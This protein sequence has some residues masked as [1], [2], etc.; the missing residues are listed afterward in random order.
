MCDSVRKKLGHTRHAT[1]SSPKPL[2]K[3]R[4][5]NAICWN[6]FFKQML[7]VSAFYLEKEK[8]FTLRLIEIYQNT[9]T[10][11]IFFKSQSLNMP[12]QIQKMALAVLIFSEGFAKHIIIIMRK[13]NLPS[14][15][16]FLF[17]GQTGNVSPV[18]SNFVGMGPVV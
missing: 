7:K 13:I 2:L 15:S 10:K 17:G 4:T 11:R 14:K 9:T 16:S 6:S 5:G 3:I 12:R 18:V 8:S 1:S